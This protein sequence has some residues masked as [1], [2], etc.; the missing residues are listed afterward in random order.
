MHTTL[1]L[2]AAHQ[3]A[4]TVLALAD[5][6]R[7]LAL[8]RQMTRVAQHIPPDLQ[9]CYVQQQERLRIQM[10]TDDIPAAHRD[11]LI[12]EYT[13][14]LLRIRHTTPV[15]PNLPPALPDLAMLRP[16]LTAAYPDG[17]VILSYA[18]SGTD[19]LIVTIDAMAITLT[20]TP[21]DAQFHKLV[22][23][24]STAAYR[25][26]TYRDLPRR[27]DPER[28]AWQGVTELTTRLL[29]AAVRARLHPDLRLLIIPSEPLHTLP[30]AVLRW[31]DAW[32]CQQ[33]IL[34]LLPAL[35]LWSPP[36]HVSPETSAALLL[37]CSQ[38]GSRTQPLPHASAE[39]DLVAAHWPGPVT[40]W[41]D[42][43]AT[44]AALQQATA[45]GSLRHYQVLHITSHAQLVGTQGLLA[46]IK[47]WDADLLQDE[48]ARLTLDHALVVLSTC[49]GAASE[50]LPGDEVLSLSHA[51]LAAGARMVVASL[52]PVYDQAMQALLAEFYAAL[53]RGAD[54]PTALAHAQRTAIAAWIEDAPPDLADCAP[55]VVGG[56]LVTGI[57]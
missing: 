8:Q 33:A 48:V 35:A 47:L 14:L 6:H 31:N 27:L 11:A 16:Q 21:R 54:A 29:P 42:A 2:A 23:Q 32:L 19:L 37:G 49:D 7:T 51:F 43:A 15:P 18:T 50:V 57:G 56:L 4:E 13:D 30:W 26:Y 55:L 1:D 5:Q 44:R 53:V 38:F 9:A 10:A 39:L 12:A 20:R 3:E 24:A 17:W 45:D 40:R 41:H 46:H 22:M 28:P 52:W 36:H 34:H 25:D